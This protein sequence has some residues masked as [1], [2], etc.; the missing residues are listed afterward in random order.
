MSRIPAGVARRGGTRRRASA[1]HQRAQPDVVHVRAAGRAWARRSARSRSSALNPAASI[2]RTTCGWRA[3]WPRARRWRFENARSYARANEAS[4]LKDEFLA[5]LSHEL[6]T[7]L[8]AVLG[9]ARMLRL[10]TITAEKVQPALEVVERNAT[11]LK[12]I[13]EDVLD[14]SRI[15]AGR[16]RL[17]V[18]PVDLPAIL[19]ESL[20]H[21]DAR[22]RRE[23]R[24]RRDR[25]RP[26][27]ARRSRAMPI[28]CSRSSGICCRTRSS[29]RRA[30]ARCSSGWRGSTRTSRSR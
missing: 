20:R 28:G 21:R 8:N 23:G 2:R 7:P 17:N 18:E 19:H 26:A 14:V 10:R 29:S 16:L 11:A 15:V 25:D 13:I 24:P 30:A 3:S 9:Y 12:Q 4:R 22:R 1:D 5:T 6:R 27:D